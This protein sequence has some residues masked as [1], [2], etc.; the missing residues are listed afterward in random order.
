[1]IFN[2]QR[3]CQN[4]SQKMVGIIGRKFI[5]W[6]CENCG[7]SFQDQK[8][9]KQMIEDFDKDLLAESYQDYAY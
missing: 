3:E 8:T 4:C 2:E 7:N 9:R 5:N 6:N 1:M